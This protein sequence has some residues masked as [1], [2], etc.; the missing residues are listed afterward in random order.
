MASGHRR[1]MNRAIPIPLMNLRKMGIKEPR[2]VGT[3]KQAITI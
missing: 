1:L 3:K 2:Q